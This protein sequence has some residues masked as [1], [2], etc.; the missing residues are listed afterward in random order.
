MKLLNPIIRKVQEVKIQT[1]LG[2]DL[3]RLLITQIN[4]DT[5]TAANTTLLNDYLQPCLEKFIVAEALPYLQYQFR[6]KGVMKRTSENSLPVELKE[7]LYLQDKLNND[8]EWYAER[9]TKF[10]CANESDYPTYSANTDAD[11]IQPNKSNY[12][13]NMFLD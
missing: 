2:T 4:A 9:V 11:D 6:N 5:L 10:L 13:T 3:Y 7:I 12:S 8:A 1:L